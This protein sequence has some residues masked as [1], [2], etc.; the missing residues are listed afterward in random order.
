[1]VA[2]SSTDRVVADEKL[3]CEALEREPRGMEIED[4]VR[5]G[6]AAGVAAVMTP[7]SELCRRED[8]E[9]LCDRIR[10]PAA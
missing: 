4:A 10:R 9:R 2:S 8:T 3:R 6:V 1:V 5:L 7:G